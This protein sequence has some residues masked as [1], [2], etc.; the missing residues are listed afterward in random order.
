M[1]SG[2]F[3]LMA[4]C[5]CIKGVSALDFDMENKYTA[6]QFAAGKKEGDVERK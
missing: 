5:C 1:A 6:A 2:Y 4:L 3:C